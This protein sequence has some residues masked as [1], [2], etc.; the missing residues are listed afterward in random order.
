[1]DV[2]HQVL[3]KLNEVT[4]GKD[5]K[6]VNFKNLI[7]EM[8]FHGN[9]NDIFERL[10]REGW[11][12]ESPKPDFVSITHWG[13]MEARKSVS[14]SGM[15]GKVELRRN[16]NKTANAAKEFAGLL[17]N[18]SAELSPDDFPPVEQKFDELKDLFAQV[19]DKAK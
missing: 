18:F 16:I 3:H 13:W 10:N 14:D 5:S 2:Y 8:G 1:M 9:Y 17:E 15:A 19:K 7:K 6:I 11:I 12:S 4:G